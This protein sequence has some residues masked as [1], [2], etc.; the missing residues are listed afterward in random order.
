MFHFSLYTQVNDSGPHGPLVLNFA[1]VKV[2]YHNPGPEGT[3]AERK[4]EHD[5]IGAL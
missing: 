2:L 1:V 5:P 4:L 3:S